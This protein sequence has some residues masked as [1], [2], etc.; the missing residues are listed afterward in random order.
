[1]S[2]DGIIIIAVNVRTSCRS[3]LIVFWKV[4]ANERA[5]KRPPMK[6]SLWYTTNIAIRD[7]ACVVGGKSFRGWRGLE[8][9]SERNGS[10][11]MEGRK[12]RNRK[13]KTWAGSGL[14]ARRS[15]R[16]TPPWV[17]EVGAGE[18]EREKAREALRQARA[19]K[20]PV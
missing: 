10:W 18:G 15:E 19:V 8:V 6:S 3:K 7:V 13:C 1:M 16:E 11:G 17:S 20:H 4:G 9:N 12:K 5:N 14:A 2:R